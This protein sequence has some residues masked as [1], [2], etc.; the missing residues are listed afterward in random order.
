[1]AQSIEKAQVKVKGQIKV[2][3]LYGHQA[4]VE[5]ELRIV[6]AEAMPY[7]AVSACALNF[8]SSAPPSI[9]EAHSPKGLVDPTRSSA[10]YLLLHEDGRE[11]EREEDAIDDSHYISSA[12]P[13]IYLEDFMLY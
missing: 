3:G 7:F 5:M 11:E 8:A 1:M 13:H 10:I 4:S 6:V 12:P 9:V 2:R